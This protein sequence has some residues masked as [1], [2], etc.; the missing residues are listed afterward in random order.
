MS[1]SPPGY[2]AGMDPAT[3][4]PDHSR[5]AFLMLASRE[6]EPDPVPVTWHP[7]YRSLLG[8]RGPPAPHRSDE[9]AFDPPVD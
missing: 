5:P 1:V 6:A 3:D 9:Q 4:G 8:H 2:G 7:R